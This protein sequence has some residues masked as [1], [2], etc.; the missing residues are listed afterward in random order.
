MEERQFAM[1][2][3]A[4]KEDLLEAKAEDGEGYTIHNMPEPDP[5]EPVI[6]NRAC[7][8]NCPGNIKDPWTSE[9]PSEEGWYWYDDGAEIM[10]G[11]VTV[12][13]FNTVWINAVKE[14][15]AMVTIACANGCWQKV[16]EPLRPG[17]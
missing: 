9:P 15:G 12:D 14:T 13:T 6:I 17:G 3:Y 10:F 7:P 16:Q 8:V 2:M 5:D 1:S 4:S 11:Y